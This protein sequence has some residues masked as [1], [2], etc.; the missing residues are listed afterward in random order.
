MTDLLIGTRGSPLALWQ[1]NHVRDALTARHRGLSV[2]LKIIRTLGDKALAE[3][4]YASPGK[5]LFTGEIEG[6]LLAGSITMAVHSLKDLPTDTPAGLCIAAILR[7]EDPADALISKAGPLDAIPAGSKVFTGS[8]R[9]QGQLLALRPDLDVLPIRGNVQ[10]RLRKLDESDAAGMILAR[11]GLLRQGL[12]DRI[13]ERFDPVEFLPAA[14]QG[15]LA[16]EIRADDDPTRDLLAPL[17]DAPSR[18]AVTAERAYLA[19]MG[20]GCRAP[21]GAYGRFDGDDD[22]LTLTAMVCDLRGRMRLRDTIIAPVAD[23]ATAAAAGAALG[24]RM[25]QRG[26]AAIL[27]EATRQNLEREGA[28]S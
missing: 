2:E 3:P 8:L 9:R 26:G 19:R 23:D 25:L 11:A 13:T 27:A 21:A 1:A 18:L 17:D 24:R 14:A 15:A 4:L 16:V 6:E 10:T 12:D 7:R 5:G 28:G 22:S 20:G